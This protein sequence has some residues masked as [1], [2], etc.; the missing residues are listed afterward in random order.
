[1]LDAYVINLPR[2]AAKRR[3]M[4]RQ[5]APHA[6]WLRAVLV[7]AVDGRTAPPGEVTEWCQ[8]FCTRGTVGCFLSHRRVWQ[9]VLASGRPALVLEDDAIL[10]AQDFRARLAA[11]MCEAPPDADLLVL[12]CHNCDA[13]ARTLVD[14][15]LGSAV[16]GRT[17]AEATQNLYSPAMVA[18]TYA[19]LVTPRGAAKL[20]RLLPKASYHVDLVISAHLRELNVYASKQPLVRHDFSDSGLASKAPHLL[21]SVL[22]FP[23]LGDRPLSWLLSEPC[24]TFGHRELV[25]NGWAVVFF[26]LGCLGWGTPRAMAAFLALDC[27]LGDFGGQLMLLLSFLVGRS[28]RMQYRS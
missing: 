25:F 11:V 12:G 14:A 24:F 4:A 15:V 10:P 2:D 20:L 27:A 7:A 21:N 3:T 18:G 6:P 8:D 1:M 16:F 28:L 22:A 17:N 26:L 5:L 19:Y 9:A 13:S 23:A